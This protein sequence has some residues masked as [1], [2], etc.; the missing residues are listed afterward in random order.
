MR[1]TTKILQLGIV[2]LVALS[3]GAELKAQLGPVLNCQVLMLKYKQKEA[4]A[5]RVIKG[6]I[7]NFYPVRQRR[8]NWAAPKSP[9][10]RWSTAILNFWY[11]TPGVSFK[12]RK[13]VAEVFQRAKKEKIDKIDNLKLSADE[14]ALLNKYNLKGNL[15]YFLENSKKKA[16]VY[17]A[18]NVIDKVSRMMFGILTYVPGL[19]L[20]RKLMATHIYNKAYLDHIRGLDK[21]Q[22]KWH[23][24]FLKKHKMEGRYEEYKKNI[25]AHPVE[26]FSCRFKRYL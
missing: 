17:G 3:S 12:D 7:K 9:D 16:S 15:E 21:E 19:P 26:G 25:E 24:S 22:P 20:P 6:K 2:I 5:H 8:V 11:Y 1:L 14:Q 4:K 23:A 18:T 10:M 13:K